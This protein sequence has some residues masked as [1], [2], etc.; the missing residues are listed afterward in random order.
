M[1]I[2]KREIYEKDGYIIQKDTSISDHSFYHPNSSG[3][4]FYSRYA[5]KCII[6]SIAA[7]FYVDTCFY[8]CIYVLIPLFEQGS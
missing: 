1:N 3:P 2:K 5:D 6:I 8:R 7:N 4:G